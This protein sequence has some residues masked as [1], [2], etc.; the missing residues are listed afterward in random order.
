MTRNVTLAALYEYPV[1]LLLHAFLAGVLCKD[2]R[3]ESI[4][5]N[6][7]RIFF[8]VDYNFPYV[9]LI[10]AI[11]SSTVHCA[12]MPHQVRNSFTVLQILTLNSL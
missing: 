5:S 8:I 7:N 3:T 12:I 9:V 2:D 10:A 6:I 11:I 1:L 4:L